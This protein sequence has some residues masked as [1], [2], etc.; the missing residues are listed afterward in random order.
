MIYSKFIRKSSEPIFTEFAGINR[1]RKDKLSFSYIDNAILLPKKGKL[2]AGVAT[3][4]GSFIPSSSFNGND[5]REPYKG[6]FLVDNSLAIYVG[7]FYSVWGHAFL[8]NLRRLWFLHTPEA[9]LMIEN[10]A[11]LVY[12]CHMDGYMTDSFKSLVRMAD[13]NPDLFVQI[14]SPTQIKTLVYPDASFCFADNASFHREHVCLI[15]RILNKIPSV[16]V[17]PKIYFTRT[18]LPSTIWRE[19]GEYK[20]ESVFANLGYK[21]YS[22]E[23]L[24]LQEQLTLMKNCTHFAATEGSVAHNSIFCK[25]HTNIAII[26]KADYIN[27]YQLSINEMRDLKVSYIDAHHTVPPYTNS[28]LVGPFYLCITKE[29]EKFVGHN[30]C[31]LPYWCLPSYWWYV[32]RRNRFFARYISNRRFIHNIEMYFRNRYYHINDNIREL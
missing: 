1:L 22:P 13:I 5:E 4:E 11:K 10:G 25:P 7:C 14:T 20:I 6:T 31:H 29:L 23:K 3:Y 12:L 28:V 30:I 8:D 9:K 24:S 16:E 15:E 19:Y 21:I 27:E 2:S 17:P 26:R 32:I 18:A